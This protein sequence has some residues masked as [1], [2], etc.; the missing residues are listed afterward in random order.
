MSVAR[1][2]I[3]ASAILLCG[4][5]ALV[6]VGRTMIEDSPEV[7]KVRSQLDGK[8]VATRVQT[9]QGNS[10][11]RAATAQTRVEFAGR[12]VKF[13]GLAEGFDTTGTYVIDPTRDPGKVDFKVQAGW[14][15]GSYSLQGDRL[16]L[17]VN[18]LRLLEQLGIPTR[19]RADRLVQSPG[20]ILYEFER[21]TP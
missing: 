8:W 16:I 10:G 19:G 21:S 5:L 11:Q 17:C 1:H 7:A 6:A 14:M 2:R 3:V 12:S 13:Q 4:S 20:R 9:S 15:L 18:S